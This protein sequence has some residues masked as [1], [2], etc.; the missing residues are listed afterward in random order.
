MDLGHHYGKMARGR[1]RSMT[2]WKCSNCE[3]TFEVEAP[4][5]H[6]PSCKQVC[7][8]SD[9][10]CYIPECGGPRNIDPR[11]AGKGEKPTSD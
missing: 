3:H 6:C 4:P 7:T 1:V 8:F 2:H 5:E 9:V 11:L 10:T